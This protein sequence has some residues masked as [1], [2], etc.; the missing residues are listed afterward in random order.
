MDN[1][2]LKK[3]VE[4]LQKKLEEVENKNKLYE[5]ILSN[6][7]LGIQVFDKNGFSYLLNN[8]QK[9][10]L[11]IPDVE[12]GLGVFNVLSDPYCVANG[13]SEIYKKVYS[14]QNYQHKYEYDLGVEENKW[15]THHDS[16]VFNE[17][18]TP[19]VNEEEQV[20]YAL[21][22]IEDIT[23]KLKAEAE[24][25]ESEVKF[26]TIFDIVDVGLTITDEQGNK[27]ECNKAYEKILGVKCDV[28]FNKSFTDLGWK[29]IRPDYSIMPPEELASARALAEN[30]VI[31]GVK[32]GIEKPDGITWITANAAPLHIK[33]YGVII[34][35]IDN[36]EIIKTE[37][38]HRVFNR[39]FEAFLNQTS[40]YI[41]F[42]DTQSRILFCSQSIAKNTG[43]KSWKELIGKND[44]DLFPKHIS[45]IYLAEDEY[46]LKNGKALLNKY[47]PYLDE[48][49]EQKSLLTNKWP[50]FDEDNNVV[51]IF[52]I[53]RDITEKLES[54][55][56][57]IESEKLLKELNAT[58]DKLFS[59][60]AHDLRTPFS[61]LI[62]LNNIVIDKLEANEID[63]A[64]K[65]LK[66][67]QKSSYNALNLLDN[68]LH[69]SRLQT[70]RLEFNPTQFLLCNTLK[71]T[72]VL[73]KPN[74]SA[75]GICIHR[76][77]DN[78]LKIIADEFMIETILRNLISNSIKYTYTG[79]TIEISAC[80]HKNEIH[81]SVKDSGIGI[82]K[83]KIDQ[84]FCIEKN[85]STVG[86]EYEKGT[87]LGLLLCKEFVEKHQGKIWVES[88]PN[89]GTTFTFSIPQ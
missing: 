9:E 81:I 76:M 63:D 71:N 78:D 56:K 65:I 77:V 79:G 4:H 80:Q 48:N 32:M 17:M 50:L 12:H 15:D 44:A 43:N 23:N 52:G 2:S 7:P 16:R 35:Y 38:E 53:S 46:V 54:D 67:I 61:G 66:R 3:K 1:D 30:K 72:L 21:S 36:T 6:L 69:W 51:G 82:A 70:N 27:I 18:I 87:G 31:T 28:L 49:G 59:I 20:E 10:L 89:E 13:A 33:G 57:I 14:K 47:E 11:G 8:K 40:D 37:Q 55:K 39:N 41:Y 26:K 25:K 34:T 75:K 5:K 60:I 68:L 85:Y 45:D 58:K 22:I 29:V 42:K 64:K 86:T 73:L 24:L 19:L 83:E 62:G 84:L 74:Y 88:K